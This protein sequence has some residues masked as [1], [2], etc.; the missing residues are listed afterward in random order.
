MRTYIIIIVAGILANG[1]LFVAATSWIPQDSE[2]KASFRSC[3]QCHQT[4]LPWYPAAMSYDNKALEMSCLSHCSQE[5]S[6]R[7]ASVST[8]KESMHQLPSP[9]LLHKWSGGAIAILIVIRVEWL[10]YLWHCK[11]QGFG[12]DKPEHPPAQLKWPERGWD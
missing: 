2:H 10:P 8:T 4:R 12:F 9:C 5:F 1:H 7:W 11:Y 6:N 3:E